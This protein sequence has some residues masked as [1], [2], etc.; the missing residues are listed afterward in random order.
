MSAIHQIIWAVA[1]GV[2]LRTVIGICHC[3][4][5]LMPSRL[6]M[7]FQCAQHVHQRIIEPLSG[8]ISLRV[9][10]AGTSFGDAS[11]LAKISYHS[12]LKVAP[13]I[14]VELCRESKTAKE[15]PPQHPG[16][17]CCLLVLCWVGLGKTGEM[18]SDHQYIFNPANR[19]F[20]HQT[21]I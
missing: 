19:L 17:S 12:T 14:S 8:S 16:H 10:W 3:I 5:V 13:L 20:Q 21:I 9:V 6:Q 18:V 1:S 15:V 11:D 4:D 7:R 2:M